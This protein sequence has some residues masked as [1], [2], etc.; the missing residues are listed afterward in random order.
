MA[1]GSPW[2]HPDGH[3]WGGKRFQLS[4]LGLLLSRCFVIGLEVSLETKAPLEAGWERA[5]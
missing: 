4:V 1:L 3:F 2:E 5:L